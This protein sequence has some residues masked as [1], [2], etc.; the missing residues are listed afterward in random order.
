MSKYATIKAIEYE[1]DVINRQIDMKIITGRTY[2]RD[3]LR[4]KYLLAQLRTI[5]ARDSFDFFGKLSQSFAT[6]VF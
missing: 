5:R 4:H 6:L 3:A 2:K 1:L